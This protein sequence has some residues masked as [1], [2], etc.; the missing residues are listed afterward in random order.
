MEA[1]IRT[2][3]KNGMNMILTPA[4]TP[5]LD[6]PVGGERL[7]VQL[8]EVYKA[9]E[10]Y[11]FGFDKLGRWID[12]CRRAGKLLKTGVWEHPCQS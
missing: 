8:V 7:T 11:T 1:F 4:F 12:L 2:A 9:G 5:P 10:H 6:T 3:A